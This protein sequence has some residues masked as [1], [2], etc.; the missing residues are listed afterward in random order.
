MELFD[1]DEPTSLLIVFHACGRLDRKYELTFFRNLQITRVKR[2]MLQALTLLEQLIVT[3][4]LYW[5]V[6]YLDWGLYS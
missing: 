6:D 1:R 2:F 3:V 4:L 5:Y